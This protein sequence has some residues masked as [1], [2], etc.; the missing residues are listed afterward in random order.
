MTDTEN[1]NKDKITDETLEIT[2]IFFR[3]TSMKSL[4]KLGHTHMASNSI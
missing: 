3:N 4:P 1:I 2:L